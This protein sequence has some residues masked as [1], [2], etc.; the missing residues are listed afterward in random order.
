MADRYFDST[1]ADALLGADYMAATLAESGRDF[2]TLVEAATALVR[3]AMKNSG[4]TPPTS[5]DGTGV[6]EIIKL[7][8]LGQFVEIICTAPGSTIPLPESWDTNPLKTA[9]QQII[10]GAIQPDDDPSSDGAVGGFSI[11]ISSAT[12]RTTRDE[13]D[14]W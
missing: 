9:Y 13:M 12:T 6:E 5:T 11:S 2:N 14:N 3:S 10:D 1:Y 4:Y 8:T 7:A